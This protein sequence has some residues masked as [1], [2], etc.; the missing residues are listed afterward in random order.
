MLY[1]KNLDEIKLN[2]GCAITL[3][4]FDG[5]HKGHQKL[6]G[7][8]KKIAKEENLDT[9]VFTFTSS[10]QAALSHKMSMSILSNE[11]RERLLM[12]MGIDMLVECPFSEHIRN[13]EPE[14]FVKDVLID[15]LKA[16]YAVIGPDFLFGKDRKGNAEV[17][18]ELGEKYGMQVKVVDKVMYKGEE[19]SS[20]LIR[21]VLIKGDIE[22]AN[23][24]L[25]YPYYADGIVTPGEHN[26]HILGFPTVN[27]YPDKH[28]ILPPNGVYKT[29]V[30]YRDKFYKGITN[31]GKRPTLEGDHI[32][33][34][35]NLFDFDEDIYGEFIRVDFYKFKRPEMKFGSLDELKAQIDYDALHRDD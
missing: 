16:G 6:I 35:T 2:K 20:T 11:E 1:F 19:I 12:R 23:E 22:T 18:K 8:I 31:I 32:S 4:K 9:C 3:G 13:M 15:T 29:E 25:G 14:V 33:I 7:E 5:V 30:L 34:E 24:L 17:L 26:G 10:P 27:L 21:D 28:K